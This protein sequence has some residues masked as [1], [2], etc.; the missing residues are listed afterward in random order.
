MGEIRRGS[1]RRKGGK[2][3]VSQINS[4]DAA[5]NVNINLVGNQDPLKKFKQICSRC[6]LIRHIGKKL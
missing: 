6:N 4:Y 5:R 1:I 2:R 3:A